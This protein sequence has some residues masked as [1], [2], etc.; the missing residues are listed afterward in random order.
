MSMLKTLLT[1]GGLQ[2]ATMVVMLART[3]ILA[4]FLGP[5]GVGLMGVVDKLLAVVVQGVSL[6][7]PFAAIRFLPEL[8]HADRAEG[9][10]TFRAMTLTLAALAFAAAAIGAAV[11]LLFPAIWG[12][13]FTHYPWLLAAGFLSVPAL[14]LSPFVQN[15][16][17][18][19]LRHRSSMLF[20][21]GHAGVLALAGLI[22]AA[23]GSVA[24]L[25][26]AYAAMAVAWLGP[27]LHRLTRAIRPAPRPPLVGW[28][29]VLP[30]QRI[31]RFSAAMFLLAVLAPFAALYAHYQV[32][33]R[34]G[35]EAAGWMQA[36][37]GISLAVR[38]VLGAAHPIYLTPQLNKGGTWQERMLWAARFQH[39]WCILAAVLVPPLLIGADLAIV[40]L[41]SKS[42]LPATQYVALFVF[43]EVLT[44]QAGI[45]QG[46]IVAADRIRFHVT[47]NMLSQL[48][49]IAVTWLTI[50][51]FGIA[52]AAFGAIASQ[53]FIFLCTLGYLK[54][55]MGLAPPLRTT[56]LMFYVLLGIAGLGRLGADGIVLRGAGGTTALLALGAFLAGLALFLTG[57]DRDR[58]RAWM[59]RSFRRQA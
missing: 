17:A 12:S 43:A 28:R 37:I 59:G 20:G 31:L 3:K 27:A 8:C 15:A 51:R 25:Y 11:S 10:R 52:G 44:M 49:F 5:E 30:S 32:L 2:L 56:S 13:Q 23:A 41:Y 33:S 42:F 34:A 36:A 58:I 45:Y 55:K 24:V 54:L 35:V 16:F 29:D 1:I 7:L 22:G 57:E 50:P 19:I 40:I 48:I 6:S 38:S 9:Y 26:L 4:V 53:S 47:Q 39:L 21:L 46:L 14:A 18:G